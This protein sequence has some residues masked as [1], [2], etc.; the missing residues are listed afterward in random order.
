MCLCIYYC[1]SI[2]LNFGSYERTKI[3][4]IF[5]KPSV[6][7]KEEWLRHENSCVIY[8]IEMT[9]SWK[10]FLTYI[11]MWCICAYMYICMCIYVFFSSLFGMKI[12]ASFF[13]FPV[14]RIN[15][16]DI[17]PIFTTPIHKVTVPF[18]YVWIYFVRNFKWGF[19]IK[20]CFIC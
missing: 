6:V 1:W 3:S 13:L 17:H 16:G 7:V 14:I 9:P 19:I 11:Y 12:T 10:I 18:V 5:V 4:T 15:M 8:E 2:S 20:C